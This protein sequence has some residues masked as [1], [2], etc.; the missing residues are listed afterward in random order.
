M[1]LNKV[2][3]LSYFK[4][5]TESLPHKI[6]I[7]DSESFR[8]QYS[9]HY[10]NT[11]TSEQV[12]GRELFD[13]IWP[14]HKHTFKESLLSVKQHLKPKTIELE[15]ASYTNKTGTAWYKTHISPLLNEQKQIY[16]FLMISEDITEMKLKEMEIINKSEK[17]KAILNNTID[18]ICSIDLNYNITEFNTVFSDMIKAG[19]GVTL[20]EGMPV[21]NFI[22]PTKHDKLKSI[23]KRVANGE[24]LT[25]VESFSTSH[26]TMYN[27]TNYHPIYNFNQKIIGISI[28]SKNITNRKRNEEKIEAALKEKEILLAE[29]HHRIKNNLA[30]VSSLLQ[31]QEIN[32]V[33]DEAREALKLSRN[34][35][36]S[37]ALVHELLYKNDSFQH[38]YL[39]DYLHEL[40]HNLRPDNN[41]RINI[42]GI[43]VELNID[44]AMPLGLLLNELMLNTFKH[45]QKMN[46]EG[47]ITINSAI[48]NHILTLEYCDCK[49]NFPEHVDFYNPTTTGLLLIHT[50]IQQLDG[51]I[52]LT[53]KTPPKYIITLPLSE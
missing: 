48:N 22:D 29:I 50:F 12:I 44:K 14:E 42:S 18:I 38:I 46:S 30:I 47:Q 39:H 34:R 27:E 13:F 16:G 37:T 45:S 28:F 6:I 10:N 36:K 41:K 11:I 15:G 8:I 19:Y 2:S 43:P 32:I 53:N 4:S 9:N 49:G 31:L 7:A 25:D 17:I 3:E 1:G 40:F 33:S 21:L 35:I 23:Y 24:R 52:E 51:S 20:T 26:G 5:L